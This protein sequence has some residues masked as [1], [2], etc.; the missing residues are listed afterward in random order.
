MKK[1]LKWSIYVVLNFGILFAM[2]FVTFNKGMSVYVD[3]ILSKP[4]FSSIYIILWGS[5]MMNLL[6]IF[7]NPDLKLMRA[8]MFSDEYLNPVKT[9]FAEFLPQLMASIVFGIFVAM[10]ASFFGGLAFTVF[11]GFPANQ[12][13][14]LESLKITIPFALIASSI[15]V[16]I[17][18]C[19]MAFLGPF[20]AFCVSMVAGIYMG[21][22]LVGLF[23]GVMGALVFFAFQFDMS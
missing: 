2:V 19:L 4:Y 3:E 16:A 22:F 14:F 11:F 5:L 8:D 15:L 23:C 20:I 9:Y 12:L 1:A 10:L 7:L 18:R 6:A 21:G 17:G 13:S